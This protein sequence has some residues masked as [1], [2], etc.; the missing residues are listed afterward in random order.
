[1]HSNAY[2]YRFVIIVTGLAAFLLALASTG[3]KDRQDFNRLLD[4]KKNVLKSVGEY[5]SVM[6]PQAVEEAYTQFISEKFLDDTG[7]ITDT[8]VGL[9]LFEYRKDGKVEG[10][11]L[12]VSGKGLWST[13]KG[14]FAVGTDRNTVLGITFYEHGETP[15]LGGEIEKDWFT[16]QFAGKKI[17]TSKNDLV[18]ITIAKGKSTIV[19]EYH[20]DG[21]SGATLTTKGVND[22]LLRDLK[23]YEKFLTR[24]VQG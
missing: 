24:S 20:V 2:T 7:K 13:I 6:T 18:S 9:S 17:F 11:I 1:M 5:E 8:D 12:P 16:S 21:V 4:T 23:K 15:G 14:F 3:L 10:Y 19:D 22:F